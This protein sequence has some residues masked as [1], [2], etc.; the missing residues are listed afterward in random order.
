M[1]SGKAIINSCDTNILFRQSAGN[2]D[3]AIE[4]FNL[5]LGTRDFLQIAQPGECILNLNGNTTAVKFEM[6]EFEENFVTT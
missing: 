1:T 4:F 5:S 3:Q 2:V 6:T